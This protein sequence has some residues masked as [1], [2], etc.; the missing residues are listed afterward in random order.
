MD[1]LNEHPIPEDHPSPLLQRYQLLNSLTIRLKNIPSCYPSHGAQVPMVR[2]VTINN[3]KMRSPIGK[4]TTS[5]KQTNKQVHISISSLLL[6]D[7]RA[8]YVSMKDHY[9][10]S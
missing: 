2:A 3:E 7:D 5:K 8:T 10:N 9:L 4:I 1:Q 6:N